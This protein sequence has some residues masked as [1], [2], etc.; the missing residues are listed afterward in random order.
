MNRPLDE[1]DIVAM[2]MRA[3]SRYPLLDQ[4][5]EAELAERIRKGDREALLELVRSNLR[6]VLKVAFSYRNRREHLA[7][8]I[9][10][11]NI[12]LIQAARR[13]DPSYGIKFSSYAIWWIKQ[14]M[15]MY[16]VQ[17]LNGPI[18]LPVRKAL[19]LK[20]IRRDFP[21]HDEEEI[22]RRSGMPLEEV[23]ELLSWN[24][25]YTSIEG[26]EEALGDSPAGASVEDEAERADCR[27]LIAELLSNLS[28]R[29]RRSIELFYGLDPSRESGN[30]AEI[31]RILKMSR[32]GARQLVRR[33]IEKLRSMECVQCLET[34]YE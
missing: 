6:L 17:Q 27:Q 23:R 11:G 33:T 22:A 30:F 18:S 21:G 4:K 8:L 19:K 7:D 9:N 2:Y 14:A 26:R 31:G 15:N 32:E 24:V 28:E 5:R 34:Y 13:Y 16:V 1:K 20:N 25:E 3:A 10:E 12:G 29:E